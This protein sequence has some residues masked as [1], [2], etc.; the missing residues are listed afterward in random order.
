MEPTSDPSTLGLSIAREAFAQ[1]H[2]AAEAAAA[3]ERLGH[4]R[5]LAGGFALGL[6]EALSASCPIRHDL[7]MRFVNKEVLTQ[8]EQ[9][10]GHHNQ[11]AVFVH[12]VTLGSD[13]SYRR[14]DC[15]RRSETEGTQALQH[16]VDAEHRTA[17]HVLC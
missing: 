6:R 14:N 5:G 16:S 4:Q 12:Q 10:R 2:S 7:C 1:E 13:R 17:W 11:L 3:L 9:L 8:P 15:F